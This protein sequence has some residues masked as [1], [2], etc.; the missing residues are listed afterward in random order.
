MWEASIFNAISS[1]PGVC[2][3]IGPYE[4]ASKLS[5]QDETSF[6]FSRRFAVANGMP[7]NSQ[8][9]SGDMRPVMEPRVVEIV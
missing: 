5:D 9:P 8:E 4:V 1:I 7:R 6:G 2:G 3:H